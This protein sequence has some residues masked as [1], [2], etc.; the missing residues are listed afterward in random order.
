LLALVQIRFIAAL[1][2]IGK[3][4]ARK[5]EEEEEEEEEENCYLLLPLLL[6][7]PP[8]FCQ[9]PKVNEVARVFK[10]LAGVVPLMF[11]SLFDS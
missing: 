5:E 10:I 6:S 3:E 11:S 4:L 2:Q 1:V 8:F 9:V 7:A